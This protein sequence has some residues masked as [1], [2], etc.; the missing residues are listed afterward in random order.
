MPSLAVVVGAFGL[1]MPVRTG[2]AF[3][4]LELDFVR[5]L[6]QVVETV[7]ERVTAAEEVGA[8]AQ[9]VEAE[10]RTLLLVLEQKAERTSA[11]A[12]KCRLG[13]A[14]TRP[15][16]PIY[17]AVSPDSCDEF[18][19]YLSGYVIRIHQ[20]SPK[21]E[22][23]QGFFKFISGIEKRWQVCKSNHGSFGLSE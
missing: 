23:S 18:Q 10:P 5:V 22:I 2:K 17:C 1:H 3:T 11:R 15:G 12:V 21:E 4:F 6:A 20:H 7:E 8:V 13:V 19:T 9:E 14:N 16:A